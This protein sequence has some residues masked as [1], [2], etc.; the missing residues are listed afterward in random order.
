MNRRSFFKRLIQLGLIATIDPEELLWTPNKSR[1]FVPELPSN[2]EIITWA[3]IERSLVP[4]FKSEQLRSA[5]IMALEYQRLLPK[6]RDLF[7]RDNLF[8]EEIIKGI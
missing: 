2:T 4:Q 3:D 6:M 1:I 8:F 7:I 5:Q